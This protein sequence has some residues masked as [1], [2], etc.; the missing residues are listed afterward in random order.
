MTLLP[1]VRKADI[2]KRDERDWPLRSAPWKVV[3]IGLLA[4]AFIVGAG[5][6]TGSILL[7][8]DEPLLQSSS[9][10][11]KWSAIRRPGR[12]WRRKIAL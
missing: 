4:G 1:V 3:V 7:N 8:R 6:F 10:R 9:R 2:G 12:F 5:M 11:Q